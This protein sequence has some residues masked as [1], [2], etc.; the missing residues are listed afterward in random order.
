VKFLTIIFKHLRHTWVRTGSTL[1]AMALCVFLFC[2]LQSVLAEVDAVVR[3]RSPR[4]LI[5]ENAL[6]PGLP[7]AYGDRIRAVPGVKLVGAGIMFGGFLRTR[8]AGTAGG[9]A[10]FASSDWSTFFHNMAVD[11]EAYFAMNPELTVPPDQF[12]DFMKD[13]QGCVVGR[14]LARKFGWKLGDHLFL[15]SVASALRKPSGPFE[16]V[17]RG[18]IESDPVKYPGTDTDALFFHHAYLDVLPNLRGWTV[19][20]MVEIDDPARAIETG[21]AIDALFENSREQ[22][23]TETEQ[24]FVADFVSQAGDLSALLNGIGIAVCFSILLVTANTMGMA[25]RE[26]RTEIA[27]MKTIGFTSAQI[28]GLVL[29]E[30]LLLGGLGGVLGL[31]GT[32]GALWVLNRVPNMALPGLSTI[33]LRPQVAALG[34]GVALFLGLAAGFM[35][36]W[37]A[38]RARVTEM[39]R[40]V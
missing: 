10:D 22:T 6:S 36:A 21:E 40:S 12:Q 2:L 26:R 18:F 1:V 38:Y 32:R 35:P 19:N 9:S 27:V 39:L 3:S 5:T 25:V 33:Q 11:A 16:L 20:L 14:R 8:R 15:E 13:P 4:R 28:M 37:R 7:L 34:L 30:A 23:V 31:G 29:A 17:V 24:A